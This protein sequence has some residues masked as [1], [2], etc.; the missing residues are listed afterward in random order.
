MKCG[1]PDMYRIAP[2]RMDEMQEMWLAQE[3][4]VRERSPQRIFVSDS[5][6]QYNHRSDGPRPGFGIS[7][8]QMPLDLWTP[9]Q[10]K[11]EVVLIDGTSYKVLAAETFKIMCS[12]TQPYRLDFGLM[13][14]SA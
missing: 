10:M 2:W 8:E 7:A 12:P 13:V 11:N 5:Q 1:V 9:D 3:N 14:D 4:R 6:Y